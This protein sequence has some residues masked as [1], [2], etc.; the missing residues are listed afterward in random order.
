MS[1][2]DFEMSAALLRPSRKNDIDSK[3]N[4]SVGFNGTLWHYYMSKEGV[5]RMSLLTFGEYA[6]YF[7]SKGWLQNI[8]LET[9]LA[10]SVEKIDSLAAVKKMYPPSWTSESEWLL[11]R[12]ARIYRSKR[13]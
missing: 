2:K 3:I 13:C 4:R 6:Q 7:L 12:T 1:Q 9:M 5:A 8:E 10:Y 11:E